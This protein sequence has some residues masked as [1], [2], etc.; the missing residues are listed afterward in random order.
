MSRKQVAKAIRDTTFA[1]PGSGKTPR[2]RG[3]WERSSGTGAIGQALRRLH[4]ATTSD[5]LPPDFEA[6]LTALDAADQRGRA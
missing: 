2:V 6:L 1:E 5:N 4:D 3:L